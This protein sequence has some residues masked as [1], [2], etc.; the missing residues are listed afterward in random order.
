MRVIV[1]GAT[2]F[3]G[4]HVVMQLLERGHKVIGVGRNLEGAKKFE[5]FSRVKF[6][7]ADIHMDF[8]SVTALA[9]EVDVLVHLAWPGLPNYSSNFHI[10]KNFVADLKFLKKVIESGLSHLTIAGTCLEYGLQ[11][12]GLS[13]KL[14]T[15][16]ITPYG[17]AKDSLRKSLEFLQSEYKFN[18]QWMRLFYLYGAGQNPKSFL[19]ELD[20]A[21]AEHRQSFDMSIGT[22]IRDYL[23]IE[24]AAEYFCKAIEN[25][26]VTGVINCCSGMPVSVLDLARSRC[27]ERNSKIQL[28]TGV[29]SVPEYEP[30]EFWG[31]TNKLDLL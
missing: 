2:G 12:G 11:S 19:P 7:E 17:F 26:A 20:L 30:Q 3:V 13:E 5:W 1:T 23:S 28:N 24:K 10:H 22:Q 31:L 6:I 16:P 18:L 29:F 27:I 14:T 4:Q 15:N 9:K 21:I 25:R 8:S